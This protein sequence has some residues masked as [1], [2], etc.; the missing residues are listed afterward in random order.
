MSVLNNIEDSMTNMDHYAYLHSTFVEHAVNIRYGIR[1]EQD[2]LF[3]KFS[4]NFTFSDPLPNI[5]I[6]NCPD[7]FIDWMIEHEY[8]IRKNDLLFFRWKFKALVKKCCEE[9]KMLNKP[10]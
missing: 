2:D 6:D 9:R 1:Y 10:D 3:G 5:M 7:G 8:M 4:E